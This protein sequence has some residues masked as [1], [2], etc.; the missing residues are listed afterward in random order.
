[1]E[2]LVHRAPHFL[3]LAGIVSLHG[4]EAGFHGPP[5]L[6]ETLIEPLGKAA[7]FPGKSFQAI[8]LQLP[9]LSY[10]LPQRLSQLRPGTG[11]LLPLPESGFGSLL[12]A[13]S[14]LLTLLPPESFQSD[15]QGLAKGRLVMPL[16]PS[17]P[18]EEKQQQLQQEHGEKKVITHK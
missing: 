12:A 4:L 8:A 14:P 16:A 6:H 18:D 2:F 15:F 13:L 3:Q 7:Q 11:P 5:Q 10:V 1:M 9:Q 17:L